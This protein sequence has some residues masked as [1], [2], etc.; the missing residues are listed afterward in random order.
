MV[1]RAK[2]GEPEALDE[3]M[4]EHYARVYRL[5]RRLTGNAAEADVVTQETLTRAYRCLGQFDGRSRLMTWLSAITV[6]QALNRRKSVLRQEAVSLSQWAE[7]PQDLRRPPAAEPPEVMREKE[8]SDLLDSAILQLPPDQRAALTLVVLEGMTY[9]D[10][11][12]ALECSKGTV[13]W[14]VWEARRR[15]W[16]LM[17]HHLK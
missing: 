13:A 12:H 8:L 6:R 11:A 14:R 17:G 4:R 2:E 3:L 7:P 16:D 10:A 1:R 15:L 5:A 9:H